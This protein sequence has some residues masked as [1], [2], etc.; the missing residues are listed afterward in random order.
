MNVLTSVPVQLV[1]EEHLGHRGERVL[2]VDAGEHQRLRIGGREGRGV[3]RH[4]AAQ[5]RQH[6]PLQLG[7]VQAAAADTQMTARSA[8]AMSATLQCRGARSAGE[9]PHLLG[10]L[11]SGGVPDPFRHDHRSAHPQQAPRREPH[12]GALHQGRRHRRRPLPGRRLRQPRP[13]VPRLARR[14]PRASGRPRRPSGPR[15]P[16]GAATPTT[17]SPRATSS[18]STSTRYGTRTGELFGA[19]ADGKTLVLRGIHI[20]RVANDKIVE[21]WGPA[22]AWSVAGRAEP[23]VRRSGPRRSTHR[24]LSCRRTGVAVLAQAFERPCRHGNPCAGVSKTPRPRSAEATRGRRRRPRPPRSP[25]TSGRPRR[26]ARGPLPDARRRSAA[27][28]G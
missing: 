7:D 18:S 19:P 28:P 12:P 3:D 2:V 14:A 15:C 16:T 6:L 24:L 26:A 27:G 8:L 13:A 11:A 17:T 1:V 5:R 10:W 4:R 21:R 9:T 20:F 22:A 23:G 25:R